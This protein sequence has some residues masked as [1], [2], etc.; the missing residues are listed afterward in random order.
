M[1]YLLL[2]DLSTPAA[3]SSAALCCHLIQ[4]MLKEHLQRELSHPLNLDHHH[5]NTK[6]SSAGLKGK[7]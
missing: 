2:L 5:L 4:H 7:Y 1:N 6:P 3:V